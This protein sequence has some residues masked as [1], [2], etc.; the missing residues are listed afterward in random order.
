MHGEG[1]MSLLTAAGEELAADGQEVAR[2]RGGEAE[3]GVFPPIAQRLD[4]AGVA[5]A[6][7]V[8]LVAV[9]AGEQL[10]GRV[11]FVIT[12]GLT[13]LQHERLNALRNDLVPPDAEHAAVR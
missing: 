11:V 9:R 12:L 13:A 5:A 8:D 6:G 7:G 2:L 1:A 4:L 10:A 3:K